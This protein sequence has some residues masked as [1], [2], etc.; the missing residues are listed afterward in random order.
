MGRKVQAQTA[1]K[2]IFEEP[3]S[4]VSRASLG[5]VVSVSGS[6]AVIAVNTAACSKDR[7]DPL[8]VGK[9]LTIEAGSSRSVALI[10]EAEAG[11]ESRPDVML[12]RV[13]LLGEVRPGTDDAKAYFD[14]G[15]R[16]YP[17]VGATAHEIDPET[18]ETIYQ[19]D[20]KQTITIGT[21]TQDAR[22]KATLQVQDLLQKHFAIL[23]T[24]GC[25][26]SSAVALILDEVLKATDA[27]R[28]LLI[29]PHNEYRS[30]FRGSAAIMSPNNLN[31]PFWLFNFEE[32]VDVIYRRRPGVSEE[33]DALADLIP[34]AK[35]RYAQNAEQGGALLRRDPDAG[36]YTVDSPVPYRMHD[37][38]ALIDE[39]LGSLD[40]REE[41]PKLRRLKTRIESV[42]NDA[43]YQ[44]MFS[45][46]TIEDTM[47]DILRTL[48]RIP[49]EGKR[50]TILELAGFPADVVD[51][52]V[53]V[54]CRLA[55]DVG[56]WGGGRVP[57]LVACEEAHRYVPADKRLGFGPTRRAISRI[58]KEGRK[59][60]VYLGLVT[61][62]PSELDPTILSQCSTIF[63]MRL[64]NET[65]HAIIRSAVSDAAASTLAS[66][67]SIGNRE[68]IAFGEAVS[69][70]MRVRFSD[71][72]SNKLPANRLPS[73]RT[74]LTEVE[75][76]D[77]VEE[78]VRRWRTVARRER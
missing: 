73:L 76:S 45:S 44:F 43:R 59:Y 64:A 8:S 69:M 7:A 1:V 39:K 66:L 42:I 70:P 50:I 31:L 28:V 47:A 53:S 57:L 35:A 3:R 16:T 17:P 62:R 48:F 11:G 10:Y 56:V 24:T 9:L 60:N 46:R 2:P 61:Q 29:D 40:N 41:R 49:T 38:L 13:E 15:I 72:A 51:A 18:L 6:R 77:F 71:L 30:A 23:G 19:Y 4:A 55:F 5:H 63:A 20:G 75:T 68:A 12:A 34:I 36:G 58:A 21:L 27:T 14:R 54:L 32:I 67:P 25:G 33:V 26:K 22:I 78:V 52:V 74:T 65:D 37:V